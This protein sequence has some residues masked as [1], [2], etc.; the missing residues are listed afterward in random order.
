MRFLVEDSTDNSSTP[1][2]APAYTEEEIKKFE[3]AE[4]ERIKVLNQ[5]AI[6]VEEKNTDQYSD[7]EIAL[8]CVSLFIKSFANLS[9]MQQQ[10]MNSHHSTNNAM[11][12]LMERMFG[13]NRSQRR[14]KSK[15]LRP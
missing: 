8:L 10:L 3:E 5:F 11:N 9:M 12:A 13:M 7:R 4:K 1:E 15:I 14:E 6:D 2:D